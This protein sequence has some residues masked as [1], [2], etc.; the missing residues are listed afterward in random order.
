MSQT[1]TGAR[2][3][4][5]PS[6]SLL[7]L[8]DLQLPAMPAGS[9][10]SFGQAWLWTFAQTVAVWCRAARAPFRRFAGLGSLAVPADCLHDL[11]DALADAV[12]GR[13][14]ASPAG[15]PA[16]VPRVQAGPRPC[17]SGGPASARAGGTS[18]KSCA[19]SDGACRPGTAASPGPASEEPG[20]PGKIRVAS[21]GTARRGHRQP[22]GAGACRWGTGKGGACLAEAA[23]SLPASAGLR[24]QPAAN[25]AGKPADRLADSPARRFGLALMVAFPVRPAVLNGSSASQFWTA[26]PPS[27]K[28]CR[29]LPS[30]AF[31]C[32]PG[33][34]QTTVRTAT[35]QCS[36]SRTL[37]EIPFRRSACTPALPP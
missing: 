11:A 22:G 28:R 13:H 34:W 2:R 9:R 16:S 15:N 4:L 17:G 1:W 26:G 5:A 23:E 25:P 36:A 14:E 37:P 33:G 19:G 27:R 35:G 6:L 3:R 24:R 8:P 10:P 7:G 20:H 18:R 32:R 29:P 31:P 21:P 12:A 30:S